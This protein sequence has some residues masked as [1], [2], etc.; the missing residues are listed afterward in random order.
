MAAM[1]KL[2]AGNTI[3]MSPLNTAGFGADFDGDAMNIH[4][5]ST[6]EAAKEAI[7]KMLPSASLRSPSDFKL[8]HLPRQEYLLGLWRA[9]QPAA[10]K[11]TRVFAT[12]QD[13]LA[14]YARGEISVNDPIKI[15]G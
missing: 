4:V 8:A 5:P 10:K 6:P 9:T 14:A 1:P 7:Q 12:K 13:A 15:S 3:H 11:A 2:V